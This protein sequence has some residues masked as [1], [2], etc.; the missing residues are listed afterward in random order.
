MSQPPTAPVLTA[1]QKAYGV[2]KRGMDVLCSILGLIVLAIPFGV[3]ALAIRLDDHG[4]VFFRQERVGRDQKPFIMLK[5]RTMRTDTPRD[6]PTHLLA[7]PMQYLTRTGRFLRRTS[8]DELPQLINILKGEMSV[9]GP[10]PALFN[11]TDLNEAREAYGVH[12]IRPGLTGWAQING[13][14]QLET[15]VKAAL[16]GEYLRRYGFKMDLRC[17]FGT[18]LAVLSQKGVVEGG[19]GAIQENADVQGQKILIISD[20]SFM[21]WQLRRELIARLLQE[22]T[23]LISAPKG[24]HWE[25]FEGMGCRMEDTPI[26]RRG[27]NPVTDLRLFFRY[28]SHLRQEKPSLVITYSIKPNIYAGFA[29]RLRKIPCYANIQGLGTA[30][31]SRNLTAFVSL[32]YEAALKRS[33]TVFFEN[34]ANAALFQEWKIIPSDRVCLLP[35]AGVNLSYHTLQPY[36]QNDLVHFLYLGR[37]IK[38]KGVGELFSAV[39]RL[40]EEGHRFILDVVGFCDDKEYED[41]VAQ[42]Q[43]DGIALFHGFQPDPRP[44]YAAADCV[45][46]PSYHEGMSNVL[47]EGA[48]AGRPLITSNIPGCQEAVDPEVTGLLCQPRDEESLYWALKDFLALAPERRAGMGKAARHRMEEHF[49]RNAV[50]AATVAK[51]DL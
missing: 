14:D 25:D 39:R 27:I 2:F 32:L 30:F 3:L 8:L 7:D 20:D 41:Q 31:Q 21:L 37:L 19:T 45:V 34:E 29:C 51:L 15:P 5:F 46:L 49:D 10:R 43:A 35:G 36:P 22:N 4:P 9:V 24:D 47:L 12:Q 44:W 48:A 11:Q 42:L 28:L 16:D 1:R 6:V 17:F 13:R 18:F 33:R 50:V 26:D 40:Y 23:V 38:E